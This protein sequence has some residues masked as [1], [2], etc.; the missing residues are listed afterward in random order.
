MELEFC[1]NP[2]V[3]ALNRGM[4]P[5]VANIAISDDATSVEDAVKKVYAEVFGLDG[6]ELE[7][8]TEGDY[9]PEYLIQ[10]GDDQ[11][12]TGGDPILFWVNIDRKH[13]ESSIW[14]E[15][16]FEYEDDEFEDDDE[17]AIAESAKKGLREDGRAFGQRFRM[18]KKDFDAWQK[19]TSK[20]GLADVRDIDGVKA[21][22]VNS[23]DKNYE[24]NMPKHIGTWNPET[25]ELACDDVSLF[26]HEV[27]ESAS[28]HLNKIFKTGKIEENSFEDTTDVTDLSAVNIAF[29]KLS[30]ESKNTIADWYCIEGT[31]E[32]FE[33]NEDYAAYI[34]R[35]IISMLYAGDYTGEEEMALQQD[36]VACGYF[37]KDELPGF[38]EDDECITEDYHHPNASIYD[39]SSCGRPS[40][41]VDIHTVADFVGDTYDLDNFCEVEAI[42]PAEA[43]CAECF[44][45]AEADYLKATEP[46]EYNENGIDL[47]TGEPWGE[48]QW[49]EP[50][51]GELED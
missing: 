46:S 20:A 3:G 34:T 37:D 11:D 51:L 1:Y 12:I 36:L 31:A 22:Y 38:E 7:D 16:E 35:D 41:E 40:S 2:N 50:E 17:I 44:E 21:C 8:V 25:E 47:R 5:D 15:S 10:F 6:E 4:E 27:I 19:A 45:Q 28:S 42:D 9:T 30:D 49:F 39:C 48:Y 23:F 24:H 26:G 33:T 43:I 29:P 32:D 14:E 13:Y 18:P